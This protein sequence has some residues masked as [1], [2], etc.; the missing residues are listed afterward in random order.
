MQRLAFFK[1]YSY[2]LKIVGLLLSII[3]LSLLTL[4]GTAYLLG[5][6]EITGKQTTLYYSQSG[7]IIGEEKGIENRYAIE[8]DSI[9]PDLIAATLAIE[10]KNFYKHRGFDF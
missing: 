7:E 1:K 9:S 2:R 10:D 3:V 4:Y 5:P 6:P 8:L